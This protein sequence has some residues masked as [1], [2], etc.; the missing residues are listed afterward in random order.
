MTRNKTL[1][2]MIELT[3]AERDL[4]RARAMIDTQAIK[5]ATQRLYAARHAILRDG[6]RV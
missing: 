1:N 6:G 5:A 3:V 4:D 2:T